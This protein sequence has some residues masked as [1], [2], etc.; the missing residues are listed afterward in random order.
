MARS[1][2]NNIAAVEN[3]ELLACNYRTGKYREETHKGRQYL[4]VPMTMI[5]PGV[6]NGSKGRLLYPPDEVGKDPSSWNGVP[7]TYYHPSKDGKPVSASHPGIEEAQGIGF[8]RSP[9]TGEKL[10][11]EA[12]IDVEKANK[13]DPRVVNAVRAGKLMEISTGL[14]TKNIKAPPGSHHNGKRYDYTARNY[15]PDHLAILPDQRGACSISDG[16]GLG[17][18]SVVTDNDWTEWNRRKRRGS[19]TGRNLKPEHKEFASK[20]TVHDKALKSAIAFGKGSKAHERKEAQR[21]A[22][23]DVRK[24]NMQ[25]KH[26][27]SAVKM[28]SAHADGKHAIRRD[29]SALVRA[30]LDAAKLHAKHGDAKNSAKSTEKAKQAAVGYSQ[31][32]A[33][34]HEKVAKAFAKAGN[35]EM[36]AHYKA[37]AQFHHQHISKLTGGT[38]NELSVNQY[39][40]TGE[41]EYMTTQLWLTYNERWPQK[42]R[43]E[44]D[45]S[46]FA[47]PHESFPIKTQKDVNSAARLIGHAEDP[48]SVKSRIRSIAKRKGLTLPSSWTENSNPKGINQYTKAAGA[49]HAASEKAWDSTKFTKDTGANGAY[50]TRAH[51]NAVAYSHAGKHMEAAK[52]HRE[53][54]AFHERRGGPDKGTKASQGYHVEA[55]KLHKEAEGLHLKAHKLQDPSHNQEV[56][57]FLTDNA[58][59]H[60]ELRGKLDKAIRSKLTQNDPTPYIHEVHDDHVKYLQQGQMMKCNYKTDDGTDEVR[61]SKA[62]PMK[63]VVS[64]EEAEPDA[65]TLQNSNPRGINQYTSGQA[66]SAMES[67]GG[68]YSGSKKATTR[69]NTFSKGKKINMEVVSHFHKAVSD[70]PGA[71]AVKLHAHLS[72]Q[73]HSV[74][75]PHARGIKGSWQVTT[76]TAGG[77]SHH[78]RFSPPKSTQNSQR[79]TDRQPS[80]NSNRKGDAMKLTANQRTAV[81]EEL[82]GNQGCG[83]FNEEDKDYL[84][85][86]SDERL[87]QLQENHEAHVLE[88]ADPDEDDDDD[89]EEEVQPKKDKTAMNSERTPSKRMTVEEFRATAPPEILEAVD[90]AARVNSR[91]KTK[92]IDKLV[93]HLTDKKTKER[94]TANLQK[95]S[96]DQLEDRL[97]LIPEPAKVKPAQM[98]S[99]YGP[100]GNRLGLADDDSTNNGEEDDVMVMAPQR[101][102]FVELSKTHSTNGHA[103]K[104]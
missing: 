52:S 99:V 37:R 10:K 69:V 29:A 80:H 32:R 67:A 103:H 75:S 46:D 77:D 24:A 3:L 87:S 4:V 71:A 33:A 39:M 89:G 34:Q 97:L 91:E 104:N 90:N 79:R 93:A 66:K 54:V 31:T 13:L 16:C 26:T 17:V 95:E 72:E 9:T 60:E 51:S 62:K 35:H 73:G 56:K 5:V 70:T 85:G 25:L 20:S 74:T 28:A 2:V 11:G 38:H 14:Y 100:T 55:I 68:K 64:Y 49:A 23:A 76:R 53:A 61:L 40:P 88:N 48:E 19:V 94:L 58:M 7:I 84:G 22:S 1:L 12:W 101:I 81:I 15:R 92:V 82:V 102:D 57:F 45:E 47:G 83:C 78:Y 36:A 30:H 96:L 43:D 6:L 98:K 41:R 27:Q 44:L 59:S 63:Q 21:D 8:V 50:S 86:L 42:K 65:D 18:N